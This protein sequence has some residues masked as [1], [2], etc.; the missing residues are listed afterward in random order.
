MC[1]VI[2]LATLF[3]LLAY[4]RVF[5]GLC[6]FSLHNISHDVSSG[7]SRYIYVRCASEPSCKTDENRNIREQ[8]MIDMHASRIVGSLEETEREGSE[9]YYFCQLQT[10]CTL[11]WDYIFFASCTGYANSKHLQNKKSELCIS[12]REH[13]FKLRRQQLSGSE[14]K[15]RKKYPIPHSQALGQLSVLAA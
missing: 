2:S 5:V 8:I 3:N 9:I 15:L 11:I 6:F 10:C 13:L 7:R 14:K 4:R 1:R 12:D